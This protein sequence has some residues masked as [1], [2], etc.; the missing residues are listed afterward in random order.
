MNVNEGISVDS[1]KIRI[2]YD[3]KIVTITDPNFFDVW[4]WFNP[5]TGDYTHSSENRPIYKQVQKMGYSIDITYKNRQIGGVTKPFLYFNLLGKMLK[6]DYLEGITSDNVRS[7]YDEIMDLGICRFSF[8][9]FLDR[10]YCTDI[11]FKRDYHTANSEFKKQ[12]SLLVN[13]SKVSNRSTGVS[14]HKGG[15]TWNKRA[16]ADK[17]HPFCKIYDK[18]LEMDLPKNQEF[19][20]AYFLDEDFQ[21]LK[22]IEF[23][24]KDA[25]HLSSLG[26]SDS[27]LKTILSLSQT[28][29]EKMLAESF[30]AVLVNQG[31]AL[32]TD[33]TVKLAPNELILVNGMRQL[34][35]HG[36]NVE[37]TINVLTE[38]LQS[39]NLSKKKKLLKNLYVTY[40]KDEFTSIEDLSNDVW[41]LL[42]LQENLSGVSGMILV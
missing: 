7:I 28:K 38:G 2:P 34:I 3:E 26:I 19:K 29:K 11:D 39:S 15:L 16:K 41:S 33:N 5:Q 4:Y 22:R 1:L 24:I 23:T 27:S 8:D 13:S 21:D 25:S 30:G 42:N 31:G 9:T 6:K 17:N 20:E 12:L 10:S 40:L 35:K 18:G 36:A 32:S 37:V 14:R